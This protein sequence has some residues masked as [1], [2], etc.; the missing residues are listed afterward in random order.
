MLGTGTNADKVVSYTITNGGSGFS[1]GLV[2]TS[3]YTVFAGT[4]TGYTNGSAVPVT[5]TGGTGT[6]A[7][8]TA[9]ISGGI[10]QS[11]TLTGSGSGYINGQSYNISDGTTTTATLTANVTT[12]SITISLPGILTLTTPSSPTPSGSGYSAPPLVTIAPPALGGIQATATAVLGLP[13]TATAGQVE[14]YIITNAGS[15]YSGTP[16][17]T[18]APPGSL[19]VSLSGS[20]FGGTGYSNVNPPTVTPVGGTFTSPATI[21]AIV[22]PSGVITGFN[23]VGGNYTI[24]PTSIA[25]AAPPI[26]TLIPAAVTGSLGS[27]YSVAP[28]VTITGSGTGATAVGVLGT[29]ADA[30]KIVSY[31]V[32]SFGTY[33][34]SST[35]SNVTVA[36]PP[37]GVVSLSV[38]SGG[39]G[40]SSTNLPTVTI[41]NSTGTGAIFQAIVNT[42]GAV[43]GFTQINPG[44]GYTGLVGVVIGRPGIRSIAVTNLTLNRGYTSAPVVTI[45]GD[46]TGAAATATVVN[47]EVTAIAVDNSGT[48]YSNATVS[49]AYPGL[50]ALDI[51]VGSPTTGTAYTAAPNV[52]VSLPDQ[53]GGTRATATG[54]LNGFGQIIGYSNFF[55]GSGYKTPPTI[56]VAAPGLSSVTATNVSSGYSNSTPPTVTVSLP[57]QVGGTRATA[58]ANVNANG[59]VTSYNFFGGSGYSTLPT[60]I[61]EKPG[62]LTLTTPGSLPSGSGYSSSTPPTVIIGA[63]NNAGGT[64]ATATANVNANGNVTSYT[65]TNIGSGY[66]SAPSVQVGPPGVVSVTVTNGGIGYT[67]SPTVTFVTVNN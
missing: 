26:F 62:L 20:G 59:N 19:T 50:F 41:S 42:A 47:G 67:S 45:T 33:T 57:D 36:P 34:P 27:G 30:G 63:P 46:G 38:T 12:P 5:I 8:G 56:T 13:G 32:T 9:N 11:V 31:N 4:N 39:N 7:S 3:N 10:I 25:I 65:I 29:G 61:V 23:V 55:G 24:A 60:I 43:T 44:T 49:V 21:T 51:P 17:V 58:T 2:T 40:Y 54:I 35:I 66:T 37:S 48:G 1:S 28:N 18:V 53:V 14:S 52:T 16:A 6:P 22:N 64:Q 15:G